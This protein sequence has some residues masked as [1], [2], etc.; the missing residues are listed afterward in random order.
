MSLDSELDDLGA[1]L[2]AFTRRG[3]LYGGAVGLGGLAVAAALGGAHRP[4]LSKPAA[5]QAA[6]PAKETDP[7]ARAHSQS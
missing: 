5:A 2:A 3:L 4:A 6:P 1:A 7:I